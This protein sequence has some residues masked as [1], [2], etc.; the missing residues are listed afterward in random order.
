MKEIKIKWRGG[1]GSNM[2]GARI[3]KMIL[4]QKRGSRRWA[5]REWTEP[6]RLGKQ[7]GR[8]RACINMLWPRKNSFYLK[9][10]LSRIL[11]LF[12]SLPSLFFL[13]NIHM[14]FEFSGGGSTWTQIPAR[15]PAA[16]AAAPPRNPKKFL[17]FFFKII[18]LIS[19][20]LFLSFSFSLI[21]S[22]SSP[23]PFLSFLSRFFFSSF[24]LI[25]FYNTRKN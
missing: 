17:S 3:K 15:V 5:L 13:K 9:L 23:S 8:V 1:V 2:G 20:S 11:S 6:G 10:S 12:P 16:G 18:F 19:S 4:G 25:F 24:F 7:L 14:F 21:L 22:L